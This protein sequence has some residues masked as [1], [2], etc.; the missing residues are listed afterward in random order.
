MLDGTS[1]GYISDGS[2]RWFDRPFEARV[3]SDQRASSECPQHNSA[4]PSLSG[5][6]G[7]LAQLLRGHFLQAGGRRFE[8]CTA[9]HVSLFRLVRHSL[10]SSYVP[11]GSRGRRSNQLRF[12]PFEHMSKEE[13]MSSRFEQFL[14]EREDLL[15][16][17]PNTI[18]SHRQSLQWL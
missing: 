9:H 4:Y 14:R 8:S 16:V 1:S 6:R 5:A 2:I 18:E 7:G 3:D 12:P 15:G 10:R 11:F 13:T 17:S